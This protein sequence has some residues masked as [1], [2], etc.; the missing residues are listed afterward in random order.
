MTIDRSI[1]ILILAPVLLLSVPT[2]VYFRKM[3]APRISPAEQELINFSYQKVALTPPKRQRNFSGLECPVQTSG[4]TVARVLAEKK[5][6]PAFPP[7]P[8]PTG[9]APT[10][11]AKTTVSP[12]PRLSMIYID[13]AARMAI[14]DGHVLN[15]GGTLGGGKII[16]IDKTRVLFKT[17]GR[18]IWL[19]IN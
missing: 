12:L 18:E 3:P 6:V 9:S 4:P 1:A 7:G 10:V 15:E 17:T 5:K 19:N 2:A 14:L 16:R 11:A 8:I 13:G